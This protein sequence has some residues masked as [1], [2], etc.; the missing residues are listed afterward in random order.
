MLVLSRKQNQAIV[1]NGNIR[2]TVISIRG[3]QVRIGIEAPSEV[4]VFREELVNDNAFEHGSRQRREDD[5]P[6]ALPA[7]RTL[8][9]QLAQ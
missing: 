7:N 9:N 5:P 6:L 2:V 8:H 4:S 3:S 1:I